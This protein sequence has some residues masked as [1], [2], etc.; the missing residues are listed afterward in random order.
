M[1]ANA[2]GVDAYQT[3]PR[4]ETRPEMYYGWQGHYHMANGF[5]DGM[6]HCQIEI[7]VDVVAPGRCVTDGSWTIDLC[8]DFKAPWA[9]SGLGNEDYTTA[10]TR[11]RFVEQGCV[12]QMRNLTDPTTKEISAELLVYNPTAGEQSVDAILFLQRDIMPEVVSEERLLLPAGEQRQISLALIERVANR[13]TLI[14][15]VYTLDGESLYSRAYAWGAPREVRWHTS[16]VK[17]DPIVMRY[18]LYPYQN[19]LRVAVDFKGLP[20]EALLSAFSLK[21]C[22]ADGSHTVFDQ[23]YTPEVLK[24]GCAEMQFT[25]QLNG[26]YELALQAEGEGVPREPVIQRLQ[27]IVYDW[28]HLGLGTSRTV[29]PPFTPITVEGNT[30]H[31][32]MKAYELNGAGV[33]DQVRTLD[34]QGLAWKELL[35]APMHYSAQI[36]GAAV[37]GVP[38]TIYWHE[39]AE[40]RVIA[41][42]ECKLGPLHLHSMSTLEYDGMLRVDVTLDADEPTTVKALTLDIP[43][44]AGIARMIH[45]MADGLRYPILTTTLPAGEG[46]VWSS[47]QMVTSEYPANFCTYIFLGDAARGLCWFAENDAGWSWDPAKA[48]LE[49]LREGDTIILRIH[50]V[51]QP[52]TLAEARTLTF[53]LQGSPVKPR[54]EGW[55]HRWFTDNYSVIGC[56]KHWLSTGSYGAFY[57]A[58]QDLHLWE[59]IRRGNREHLTDAEVESVVARE[60]ASQ[61]HFGQE[62]VDEFTRMARATLRNRF[63]TTIVF[64]YNRSIGADVEEYQTFADEWGMH[65]YNPERAHPY[66]YE[67]QGGSVRLLHRFRPLLVRQIL[68]HCR[69]YRRVCG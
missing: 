24:D 3:F 46:V 19:L 61:A 48:N 31:T 40:D 59:M 44:H 22:S 56:D 51:S 34:Q 5:H 12:V 47:A 60:V 38:G 6:W 58:G 13:F 27:R 29:Y 9:F 7:P 15:A 66:P 36:D 32:V 37:S 4:G 39:Q 50:L 11:F 53:G 18:A 65:D 42:T 25:L 17:K 41:G 49:V 45:A 1:L 16:Q 33:L 67:A 2:S 52:F 21:L 30:L 69:Q 54:L 10:G 57:P 35:A 23:Q 28:E 20:A 26:E 43:L 63:G 14:G 68:R 8:R 62:R 55:R 64:Y